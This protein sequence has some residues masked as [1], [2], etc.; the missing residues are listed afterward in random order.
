MQYSQDTIGMTPGD[1]KYLIYPHHVLNYGG[2]N[3]QKNKHDSNV[4]YR[5]MKINYYLAQLWKIKI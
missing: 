1:Y 5:L 3:K 2:Y 4:E